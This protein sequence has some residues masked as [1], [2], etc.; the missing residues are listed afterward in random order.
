MHLIKHANHI[1]SYM[2]ESSGNLAII[3]STIH[4]CA[5]KV[6]H[7]YIERG[8]R[9]KITSSGIHTWPKLNINKDLLNIPWSPKNITLQQ[10]ITY[11][12]KWLPILGFYSSITHYAAYSRV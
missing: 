7:G 5:F 2:I 6:S 3:K 12:T 1:L 9:T 11:L 4:N 8:H 10:I